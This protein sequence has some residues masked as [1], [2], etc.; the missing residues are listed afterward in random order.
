MIEE[1]RVVSGAQLLRSI[2]HFHQSF[3]L[4]YQEN[5]ALRLKGIV[6]LDTERTVVAG[7]HLFLRLYSMSHILAEHLRLLHHFDSIVLVFDLVTCK[8]HFTGR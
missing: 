4:A 8:E 2:S 5:M 7:H 6:Q 1:G 3:V